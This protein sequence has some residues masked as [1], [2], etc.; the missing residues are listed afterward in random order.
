MS[1]TGVS[2]SCGFALPDIFCDCEINKRESMDEGSTRRDG[3]LDIVLP[4]SGC[5]LRTFTVSCLLMEEI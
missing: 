3:I 1:F 2:K 4:F 5:E